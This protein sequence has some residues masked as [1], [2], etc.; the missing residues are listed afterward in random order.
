[1]DTGG[2]FECAGC[3]RGGGGV[4]RRGG[5]VSR[6]AAGVIMCREHCD[7]HV[8]TLHCVSLECDVYIVCDLFEGCIHCVHFALFDVCMVYR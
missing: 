3:R 4:S 8:C 7:V 5:G 6:R 1:M 2:Q